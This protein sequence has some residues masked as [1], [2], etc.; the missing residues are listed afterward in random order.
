MHEKSNEKMDRERERERKKKRNETILNGIGIG[1]DGFNCS[2]QRRWPKTFLF[3]LSYCFD[4]SICMHSMA[5]RYLIV[6]LHFIKTFIC[7]I[8]TVFQFRLSINLCRAHSHVS[9]PRCAWLNVC[10][11]SSLR[12]HRPACSTSIESGQQIC[13]EN[14]TRLMGVTRHVSVN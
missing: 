13:M 5:L 3:F 8:K 12:L 9:I 7:E 14:A 6:H 2:A 10:A 1:T 11:Y 4:S